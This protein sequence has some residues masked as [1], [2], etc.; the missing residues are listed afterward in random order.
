[1]DVHES[2]CLGWAI[3]VV[4]TLQLRVQCGAP[5]ICSNLTAVL[6]AGVSFF[7]PLFPLRVQQGTELLN[8]IASQT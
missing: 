6:C 3:L 5:A 2:V 7:A 8:S 4:Y 1:M